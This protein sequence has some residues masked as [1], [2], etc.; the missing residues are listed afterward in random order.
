MK[1]PSDFNKEPNDEMKEGLSANEQMVD[2]I[3]IIN[4]DEQAIRRRVEP[5][6]PWSVARQLSADKKGR[7]YDT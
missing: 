4:L 3:P 6:K 1:T 2:E 5:A 7:V